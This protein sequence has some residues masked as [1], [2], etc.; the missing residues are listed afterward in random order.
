MILMDKDQELN[1]NVDN[2]Q[3]STG[4]IEATK[5]NKEDKPK[6]TTKSVKKDYKFDEKVYKCMVQVEESIKK[7]VYERGRIKEV[8]VPTGRMID[9]E[10]FRP[11]FIRANKNEDVAKCRFRAAQY[12]N[13]SVEHL[14]NAYNVLNGKKMDGFYI[15]DLIDRFGFSK[16]AKSATN[17][18]RLAEKYGRIN[19]HSVDVA[20]SKLKDILNNANVKKAYSDFVKEFKEEFSRDTDD[21]AVYGE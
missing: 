17:R 3:E 10:K 7:P 11:D 5:K 12:F 13:V 20:Q 18:S 21:K 19:S 14:L 16:G 15:T 8:L 9:V 1:E 6:K 4:Q 2:L